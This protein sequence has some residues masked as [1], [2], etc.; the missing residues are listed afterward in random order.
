MDRSSNIRKGMKDI[1]CNSN[2]WVFQVLLAI[3]DCRILTEETMSGFFKAFSLKITEDSLHIF[4]Y[5]GYY[6][7]CDEIRKYN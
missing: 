1:K 2:C 7:L 3:N 4:Y 6:I 5:P